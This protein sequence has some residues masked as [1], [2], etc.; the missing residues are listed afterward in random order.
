M[1]L[2]CATTNLGT[3]ATGPMTTAPKTAFVFA[4]GGSLGALQVGMLKALLAYGVRADVV[5]GS[6][7]GAVNAA[8][9][10]GRPT[11]Q[12]ARDLDRLWRGLRSNDIFPINW[13]AVLRF[14]WRRD[15]LIDVRSLQQIVLKNLPYRHIEDAALPLGIV[16]TDLLSGLPVVLQ[17]GPAAEAIL[18][19]CAIPAAFPPV[20]VGRRI[21]ADGGIASNTPVR[22]ALAFGAR[23]LIVLPT[24]HACAMATPPPGAIATALH[25]LMLLI[26]GQLVRDLEA[27][28]SDVSFHVVPAL[29]PLAV[30]PLDFSFSGHFIDTLEA[31]TTDWLQSGGLERSQIPDTMRL[32]DHHPDERGHL[33]RVHPQP[34]PRHEEPAA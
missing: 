22:A 12:G 1:W 29:C 9:F 17:E 30:S 11:P 24:G 3:A 34:H 14:A 16:A 33:P 32:H 15:Y 21:L 26:S 10:A 4:G 31:Q 13:R 20:R 2:K 25:S 6:S 5:V 23:R 8:Y 28:P 18:A 19:S 7:V 27:L